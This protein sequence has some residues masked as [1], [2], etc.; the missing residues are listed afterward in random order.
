VRTPAANPSIRRSVGAL[1]A[2]TLAVAVLGAAPATAQQASPTLSITPTSGPLGTVITATITNCPPPAPVP[3]GNP[4]ARLDFHYV[5][6]TPA[7]TVAVQPN[8]AGR[9][10][11][12]IEVIEKHSFDG[13]ESR[14]GQ[15][16]VVLSQ[17][18]TPGQPSV[19]FTVTPRF[20]DVPRSSPH[21]IGVEWAAHEG[22][23][24]GFADGTYRPQ[25]SLT[26]AQLTSMLDRALD[27]PAAPG[28]VGF[29]DVGASSPHADAVA[30]LAHAGIVLGYGDGTFGP[31]GRVLRGQVATMLDRA[32]EWP[33]G[34]DPG[35]S[36]VPAGH[37]H[38]RGIAAAAH[39]E[40]VQGFAD[41]TFRPASA[42]TR[43]Q[44]ATMLYRALLEG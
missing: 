33:A 41:G 34:P 27:L 23:V 24:T 7:N 21:S 29:T 38:G 26:R 11:V 22:L 32:L 19:A 44:V 13:P 20:G 30:R 6:R 15:G 40:V 8:A 5:G 12:T 43:G 16:F 31:N 28:G 39:A 3:G 25:T 42:V 9:A 37:P 35:F 10:Q 17:C 4:S 36:D 18:G 14:L 2:A 1:L